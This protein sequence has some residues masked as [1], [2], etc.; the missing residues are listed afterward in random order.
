VLPLALILWLLA[1][2]SVGSTRPQYR[3][4]NLHG[5]IDLWDNAPTDPIDFFSMV[6]SGYG[7]FLKGAS[8]T[9]GQAQLG[10]FLFITSYDWTTP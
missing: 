3:C 2:C 8:Q 5:R 6:L 9:S 10:C 4:K 1:G 7:F